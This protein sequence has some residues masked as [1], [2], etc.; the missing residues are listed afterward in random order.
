[1]PLRGAGGVFLAQCFPR[2][3]EPVSGRGLRQAQGPTALTFGLSGFKVLRDEPGQVPGRPQP[4]PSSAEVVIS[5]MGT[6]WPE[7]INT[8]LIRPRLVP[9]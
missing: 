1:M 6:N 5:L 4:S 3:S 2:A 9:G 8:G 7:V